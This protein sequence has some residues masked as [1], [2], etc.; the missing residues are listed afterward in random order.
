MATSRT[1]VPDEAYEETI[2]S[3]RTMTTSLPKEW[4]ASHPFLIACMQRR[5]YVSIPM[6]LTLPLLNSEEFQTYA[7]AWQRNVG[8][9]V[10]DEHLLMNGIMFIEEMIANYE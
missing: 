8:E 4:N 10:K 2:G 6:R 7:L 3:L 1:Y 9:T 5:G